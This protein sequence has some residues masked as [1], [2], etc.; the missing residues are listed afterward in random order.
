MTI[1]QNLPSQDPLTHQHSPLSGLAH[2]VILFDGYCHLCDRS[3]RFIIRHDPKRQF[4]FVALQSEAGILLRRHLNILPD[5]DS[6]ILLEDGRL[7]FFS[8]A[9]LKISRRLCFPWNMLFVFRM[10]PRQ[11]RDSVYR[12]VAR[13][14]FRWLGKRESCRIP[15]A[16]ERDLFISEEV[17]RSLFQS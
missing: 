1:Q 16:T 7:S 9:F 10:V 3:V 14:R 6:V 4:R 13:N 11:A 2:P 17:L 5:T 12:W 15:E 8:E